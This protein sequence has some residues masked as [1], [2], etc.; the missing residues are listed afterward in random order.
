MTEPSSVA[1]ASQHTNHDSHCILPLGEYRTGPAELRLLFSVTSLQ[2]SACKSPGL[3]SYSGGMQITP[4][5][6]ST[7]SPRDSLQSC[8]ISCS[9]LFNAASSV[10]SCVITSSAVRHPMSG[11]AAENFVLLAEESSLS[12]N[13]AW[14]CCLLRWLILAC[15]TPSFFSTSH[16]V[17]QTNSSHPV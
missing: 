4:S 15:N 3:P 14:P 2:L 13:L 6:F 10:L 9:S 8:C 16:C 17:G 12:A 1:G 11:F 5:S 7:T